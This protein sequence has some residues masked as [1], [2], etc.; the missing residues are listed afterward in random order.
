MT[1]AGAWLLAARPRTLTAAAAPVLL[2]TG[3]AAGRNAFQPLPALA[4]LFGAL[5]IQ[6]GTNLAN[7]YYDHVRGGDTEE[8]VGPIR[9]TQAGLIPPDRVRNA[10]YLVLG[11]ALLLGFYLVWVGGWPIALIGLASLVCAVAYTGGPYP[12]AYHGL[13]DLFVFLF[14]GL[15]AVGGTV[16]V[17]TLFFGPD[18]LLAGAGMGAMS[19]AILVV[20]NLRDLETDAL[21]GKNTM[22]VWL[23]HE[24]TKFELLLLVLM[25][26]GAP[27]VGLAFYGWSPWV[28]LSFGAIFSLQAPAR[29][30]ASH[31]P[32]DDPRALI[33]PLAGTARAAGLYGVLLGLGLALG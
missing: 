24:G 10:A 4:A 13:G 5:L 27:L 20:N 18:V 25:G 17:Q 3:L 16:W 22:A 1:R 31:A 28:L 15:A 30:V 11:L 9:V 6:I 29:A 23:G 19:T 32:G 21:A 2:G 12:L 26:F 7:D 33:P 14:F 8:R